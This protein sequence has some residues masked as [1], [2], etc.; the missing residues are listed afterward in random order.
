MRHGCLTRGRD[1]RAGAPA[2]LRAP[3][4]GCLLLLL[5]GTAAAQSAVE[6]GRIWGAPG[7]SSGG[8]PAR[9]TV[10]ASWLD[11]EGS[12]ASLAQDEGLV[13]RWRLFTLFDARG[14]AGDDRRFTLQGRLS[15]D[16]RMPGSFT[17]AAT[18]PAGCNYRIFYHRLTH[19][20]D[21]TANDPYLADPEL[22]RL[23]GDPL[24]RWAA[25]GFDWSRR[26]APGWR[27]RAGYE[28]I[29]QEGTRASLGRGLLAEPYLFGAPA[30][31]DRNTLTHR[32][33]LGGTHDGARVALDWN[34]EF[35]SDGGDRAATTTWQAA[36]T[37]YTDRHAWND[38]RRT[39]TVRAGGSWE[40]APRL[41][42]LGGYG[43]LGRFS[44]PRESV[45]EVPPA[46]GPADAV[47][48]AIA[49]NARAHS[50]AASVVWRPW[51]GARLRLGA[52]LQQLDQEGLTALARDAQS[53]TGTRSSYQKQRTRQVYTLG[54]QHAG[55]HG[56]VLNAD[57]RHEI[58]DETSNTISLDEFVGG[59]M[60][61]RVQSG[62]RERTLDLLALKLRR[63]LTGRLSA[64]GR[65]EYRNENV[66]EHQTA[67]V[68]QYAQGDRSWAKLRAE[69][70]ARARLAGNLD[71]D[72]G[73][74][75]ID[76]DFTR[77]DATG[78]GSSWDAHRL[79]ATGSWTPLPR[80]SL[81]GSFAWGV[82]EYGLAG[83]LPPAAVDPYVT[84][85]AT[86]KG[87]TSRLSPGAVLRP[88]NGWELESHYERVRN[89]DALANDSDRWYARLT[90]ALTPKLDLSAT[91]RRTDFTA[92]Y[93]ADYTAD[94]YALAFTARF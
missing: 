51:A 64:G 85:P 47:A 43:Y 12:G 74:E 62:E 82:E 9:V 20:D 92:G 28:H 36:P 66:N 48:D 81:F 65:V 24:V 80:L 49:V 40:A 79:F 94:L 50:G 91:W 7:D 22:R 69:V 61:L 26:V 29:G 13:D 27:L 33:W 93:N 38:E 52:R 45:T 44:R 71:L 54:F 11:R 75:L 70:T 23:G 14:A 6:Y 68:G 57:W 37:L 5:A 87:T 25:A 17:F 4:Y 59:N 3:G 77:L 46:G 16:D 30:T 31:L 67:L 72:A 73:A 89:R 18:N 41:T 39:W 35:Q 21:P 83:P 2:R 63:R 10:G 42:L 34:A 90:G 58:T 88:L 84:N 8:A 32:V 55:R 19:Y 53:F 1:R 78:G 60:L 56:T 76:E 86:Y 15:T